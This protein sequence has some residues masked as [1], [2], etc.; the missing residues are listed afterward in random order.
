MS[1]SGGS[2]SKGTELAK[3]VEDPDNLLNEA[4]Q[5]MP[6]NKA[7]EIMGKAADEALRLQVK[8]RESEDD[9]GI[10]NAKLLQAARF[11]EEMRQTETSAYEFS[12][13]HRSEQGDARIT[14]SRKPEGSRFC[15]VATACFGDIDHP[16]VSDLRAFRDKKLARHHLGRSFIAWYYEN[17]E[18]LANVVSKVPGARKFLRPIL[19]LTART[20]TYTTKSELTKRERKFYKGG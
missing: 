8:R 13:T 4:L 20:F 1:E 7:R 14:V 9:I 2:S 12:Q 6:E 19:W 3:L 5:R 17:G 18:K 15:F 10:V 16:I 11:S